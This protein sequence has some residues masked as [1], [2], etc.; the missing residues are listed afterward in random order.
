MK[1]KCTYCDRKR[2]EDN[3]LLLAEYNLGFG[4]AEDYIICQD[5]YDQEQQA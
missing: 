4:S 2:D 3:C 5:C 1:Y